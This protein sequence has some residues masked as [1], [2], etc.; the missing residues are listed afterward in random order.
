MQFWRIV[1]F[2]KSAY[3]NFPHGCSKASIEIRSGYAFD[4]HQRVVLTHTVEKI[5]MR[6]SYRTAAQCPS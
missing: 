5:V 1:S 2:F 3:D 6:W 4:I